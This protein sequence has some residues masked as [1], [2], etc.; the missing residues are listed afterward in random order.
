M[1]NSIFQNSVIYHY[2]CLEE[3]LSKSFSLVECVS[4]PSNIKSPSF[5]SPIVMWFLNHYRACD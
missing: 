3:S 5:V 4:Y 1:Q 2:I